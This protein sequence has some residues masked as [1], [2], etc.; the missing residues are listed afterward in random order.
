[1]ALDKGFRALGVEAEPQRRAQMHVL[2][3]MVARRAVPHPLPR[4]PKPYGA[5]VNAQRMDRHR[6]CK[7][8]P[9]L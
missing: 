3:R 1:M 6:I 8:A 4:S 2:H 5:L 9:H 7:R